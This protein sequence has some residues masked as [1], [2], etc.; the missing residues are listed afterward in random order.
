[1][2]AALQGLLDHNL[3]TLKLAEPGQLT[4]GAIDRD[5]FNGNL[6]RISLTHNAGSFLT[7]GRWQVEAEYLAI[8]PYQEI[9]KPLKGYTAVFTTMWPFIYLPDQLALDLNMDLGF[10]EYMFIPPSI[11]CRFRNSLPDVTI[12]LGGHDLVLSSYDYTLEW[13]LERG[14]Q[15]C[16]SA[17]VES[18]LD[19]SKGRQI[20]LGSMFLR[21]FYT[22]F[23][24]DSETIACKCPM[25]T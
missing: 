3:F 8:G 19:E 12:N 24:L 9:I 10:E 6:T 14:Q 18:E 21:K 13:P 15:R 11:D 25:Y 7:D 23:D 16:V 2:N 5:L 1:M 20:I 22:V 17:F 4:F